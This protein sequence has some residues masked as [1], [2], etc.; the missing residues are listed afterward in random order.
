M[1]WRLEQ[2]GYGSM[3]VVVGQLLGGLGWRLQLVGMVG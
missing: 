3:E 1:K 2:I